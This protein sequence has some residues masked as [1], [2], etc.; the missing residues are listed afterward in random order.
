M[1]DTGFSLE[2]VTVMGDAKAPPPPTADAGDIMVGADV[3]ADRV[4]PNKEV[5]IG[6][7]WLVPGADGMVPNAD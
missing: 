4:L 3:G 2:G 6:V 1:H 7:G 5:P